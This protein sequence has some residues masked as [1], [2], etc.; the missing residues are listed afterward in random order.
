MANDSNLLPWSVALLEKLLNVPFLRFSNLRWTCCCPAV[1][2]ESISGCD[3]IALIPDALKTVEICAAIELSLVSS[4]SIF[5][6]CAKSKR[7]ITI[8]LK[9]SVFSESNIVFS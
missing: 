8:P 1:G 2:S 3:I 5:F 6:D 4:V 7:G 9:S